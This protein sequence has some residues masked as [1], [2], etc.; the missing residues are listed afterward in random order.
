M[1]F[2]SPISPLTPNKLLAPTQGPSIVI[3]KRM[4]DG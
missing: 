1:E 4:L 2:Y 3:R